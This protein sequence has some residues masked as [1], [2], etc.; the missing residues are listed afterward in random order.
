MTV[1]DL[2]KDWKALKNRTDEFD[3]EIPVDTDAVDLPY[4]M[5]PELNRTY[6][7]AFGEYN[8]FYDAASLTLYKR[9]PKTE[10]RHKVFLD[11]SGV[12]GVCEVFI[13]GQSVGG[14]FSPARSLTDITPYM[15]ETENVL[16]LKFC[17]YRDCGKYT[18][19]GVAGGVRLLTV[20]GDLFI[21]PMGVFVQTESISDKARL[22][23]SASV[24]NESGEVKQFAVF[25]E[26]FNAKNK[27]VVKKLRK[28]KLA[29]GAEKVFELPVKMSRFYPWSVYDPYKYKVKVSLIS[30]DG[31]KVFDSEEDKFGIIES[32]IFG[33]SLKINGSP[34][35]LKGAVVMPDNGLLGSVSEYSA[36]YRKLKALKDIGFNAVR[37]VGCP[38]DAVLD[39]LDDLG[40]YLAADIFDNFGTGKFINDGHLFFDRT[41]AEVTELSVKTLRNH[42]CCI[43]YGLCNDAEES[44]GRNGGAETA[45]KIVEIIKRFDAKK[46][47]T[48][49]AFERAPLKAE[50]DKYEI[51]VGKGLSGEDNAEKKLISL[52]REK[53]LFLKCTEEFFSLA[54][55]AGYGYLYPRY[56]SDKTV[57]GRIILG[58]ASRREKAYDA[59]EETDKHLGVIG[60]FTFC[61]YD[62][63]GKQDERLVRENAIVKPYVNTSGLFDITGGKKDEAYYEE[64]LLGKKNVSHIVVEDPETMG[65]NGEIGELSHLW[66]WPKHIGKPI[67]IFVYT[68]GD[69]VALN[70]D[71]RSVGRK[72]AGKFNRHIAEFKTNFY[73][74]KLEAVSYRKGSE[75]SRCSVESVNAPKML[76]T[77]CSDKT[78]AENGLCYVNI[79]VTDKEGRLMPYAV[80]EVEVTVSGEGELVA[81]GNAD[82][83]SLVNPRS[84]VCPVYGGVCTA[85]VR[86]TGEG[87]ITV[88][89]V[90]EGL[91]SNKATVK[92]RPKPH[93]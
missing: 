29:A 10:K 66:N 2:N 60:D 36:E 48:A 75:V 6:D 69:I 26:I 67:R 85:V 42:P 18:G 45:K 77:E 87:R 8:G 22:K 19:I 71:G 33:K 23:V 90:S 56:A 14:I 89:A 1:T 83:E 53:D 86:G 74:G 3:Y 55:V 46:L 72:L 44:Y 93:K 52:A 34:V 25:A 61:A 40:L 47:I 91:L 82:P 31:E 21:S 79:S 35:K 80:R 62:F 11:I 12:S 49:N 4:D 39:A 27:R 78:I 41:Y 58:T 65:E 37:Y 54:D 30:Q 20:P 9:L 81:L 13:N 92:V 15:A 7:S 43:M 64:I 59:L 17:S 51:K 24:K 38:S 84:S 88:K 68:S 16:K 28:V 76:K 70:L 50:T 32:G 73:P 5:L 57:G 63:I